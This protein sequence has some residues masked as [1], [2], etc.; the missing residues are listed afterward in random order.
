MVFG[1]LQSQYSVYSFFTRLQCPPPP[2]NAAASPI[3]RRRHSRHDD[4]ASAHDIQ[5][6]IDTDSDAHADRDSTNDD[7][8]A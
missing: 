3:A 8:F 7:A 4:A 1:R 2:W 5:L 6:D